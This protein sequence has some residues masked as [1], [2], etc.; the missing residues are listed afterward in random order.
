MVEDHLRSILGIICGTVQHSITVA[1]MDYSVY[2]GDLA[3]VQPKP[4]IL[5]SC[6]LPV[7]FISPLH[8]QVV[9]VS[10]LTN[11]ELNLCLC[12]EDYRLALTP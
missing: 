9:G 1:V 6:T 12:P 7:C 4:F 8:V 2:T 11:N 3:C 10:L 5:H